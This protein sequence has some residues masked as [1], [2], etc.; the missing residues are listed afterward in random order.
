MNIKIKDKEQ[1]SKEIEDFIVHTRTDVMDAIITVAEKHQ[2]EL[3]AVP[4]LLTPSLKFRL[5]DEMKSVKMIKNE[6]GGELPI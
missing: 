3:E 5:K 4:K 2:I 1:F 6:G